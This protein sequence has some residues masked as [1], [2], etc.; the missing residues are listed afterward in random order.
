MDFNKALLNATIQIVDK[1]TLR[2]RV[3]TFEEKELSCTGQW[4]SNKFDLAA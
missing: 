2:Y 3:S 4:D 1:D